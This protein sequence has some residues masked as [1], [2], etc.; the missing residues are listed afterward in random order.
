MWVCLRLGSCE[1]CVRTCV[2]AIVVE[3][4]FCQC[5]GVDEYQCASILPQLLTNIEAVTDASEREHT[6]SP[7]VMLL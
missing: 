3:E 7:A 5:C 4:R 2:I 1:E 6:E